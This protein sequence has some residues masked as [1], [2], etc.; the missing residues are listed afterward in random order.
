[1]EI[2]VK[3]YEVVE[4][5]QVKMTR[6]KGRVGCGLEELSN[7]EMKSAEGTFFLNLS[8]YLLID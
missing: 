5:S 7:Y 6:K 3:Y 2:E 1:M 4:Y 8:T